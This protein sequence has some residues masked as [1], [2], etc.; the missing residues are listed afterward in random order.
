MKSK[1]RVGA[2]VILQSDDLGKHTEKK[3]NYSYKR[4]GV[5]AMQK[6]TRVLSSV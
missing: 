5:D 1:M 2:R 4:W 6:L 3:G